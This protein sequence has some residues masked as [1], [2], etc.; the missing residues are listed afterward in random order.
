MYVCLNRFIGLGKDFVEQYTEI[1]GNSVFLHLRRI[2]I[3]KEGKDETSKVTRLAIGVEGGIQEENALF[4]IQENNTLVVM[5]GFNVIALDDPLLPHAVVTSVMSVLSAD[6]ASRVDEAKSLTGTWDGEKRV[7]SKHANNLLQLENGKKI[8]PLGWKCEK[9][10]KRDNLWLNLTDGSI[11]CGRKFFDGSGGNNHALDHYAVAKHPLAVK[12]GTIT[13]DGADVYSYDEDDMVEDPKLKEHL[14]HFGINIAVMEK[15]E[16][17]MLELELDY[18]QRIGEWSLMTESDSQLKPL[19]G[20]G[21]TGLI[22]L[23][24]SCYLNS[25]MQV[26]LSIPDFQVAFSAAPFEKFMRDPSLDPTS[27]FACQMAKLTHGLLSGKYS[28]SPADESQA[29]KGQ[30][31]IRP[32]M[33]KKVVSYGHAEFSTKRQQDAQE[34]FLHLMNVIDR[35]K[36]INGGNSPTKSLAFEIEDRVLCTTSGKVSY[37]T[38]TEFNLPLPIPM[39]KVMNQREVSEYNAKKEAGETVDPKEVVRPRIPLDACFESFSFPEEIEDFYSTAIQGKTKALKTSRLKTFPDFLM[40]QIKKFEL[41]QDWV[42]KKL[43]VAIQVPEIIDLK[44]LRS[45][46]LQPGEELLPDSSSSP[47]VAFDAEA[48]GMIN[49]LMDMGFSMDA[50]KRAVHTNRNSGLENA[51]NWLF[52]HAN[53]PDINDPFTLDQPPS[54]SVSTAAFVASPAGLEAL[55]VM[56]IP[57][58]AAIKGLKETQNNVERAIDWIFSHPDEMASESAAPAPAEVS[59]TRDGSERYQLKA[60][61]SHMGSSTLCGHYVCHIKKD[62]QW[63]IFNDEKVAVSSSPPQKLAYLYLYQRM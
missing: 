22:N 20:P 53:D 10:D 47:Q 50:C 13:P 21:L 46:G 38:R 25:V 29:A 51:L 61:I 6:S 8:P 32:L 12:L 33:F 63:V 16:K 23:G 56:G 60:F 7:V 27:D 11:L 43:D 54:T 40:L 24:N 42:P 34:F 44:N 17:S 9:C 52:E 36:A 1:T 30:Q 3:P 62:G 57:E 55:K 19:Y 49:S 39:D 26:I 35:N 15:S 59:S 37:T 48:Q 31:G 58:A 45:T 4:D 5:P 41:G 28:Q 18:N 14:A 2:K